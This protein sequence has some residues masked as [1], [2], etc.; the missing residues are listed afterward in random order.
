MATIKKVTIS[1]VQDERFKMVVTAHQHR[2]IV[3]QP[4]GGGGTDQGPSPLEYQLAALAGCLGAIA[5]IIANQRKIALRTLQVEMEGE[6]DVDGLL[7]RNPSCRPGFSAIRAN[8]KLDAD[9]DAEQK[10]Q[11]LRDVESRCPISDNLVHAT[12]VHV[13]L[14][15]G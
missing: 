5:R 7:G 9:L 10:R 15:E 12:P 14:A 11:F 6:L 8:V 1:A 4:A 2:M 3:D 13:Q